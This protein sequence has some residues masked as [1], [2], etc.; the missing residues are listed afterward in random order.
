LSDEIGLRHYSPKT[1]RTY[2][3]YVLKFQIFTKSIDP[4]SLN[5]EHVKEFLD[6]LAAIKKVSATTQNLAFNS[7][8]F[9]F[10]HVLGKEFG[11]VEGVLRAKR[12]PS[13]PVIL[14]RTEIDSVLQHI[15]PAFALIVKM[16]Y[17]CGLRLFECIGLR[18]QCVNFDAGLLTIYDGKGL[19]DRTVPLPQAIIPE[20][21]AHV[22]KLKDLHRLDLSNEYAGVFLDNSWEKKKKNTAREFTWQWLFPAMQLTREEGTGDMRRYHLHETHVQKA[23][24]RAVQASGIGKRATAHTFRHSYASHLLQNNFDI[25]AIQELLGHGDVRTTM[26]YTRTVKSRS[27]KEACSPLDF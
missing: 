15:E 27:I 14:S 19:R 3:N 5:A 25:R 6:E 2:Q 24:K 13:V 4:Q 26:I 8:L 11:K 10:R 20:L 22:T 7:L 12:R 21:R 9:F 17:G 23:I 16:L 1:M 18:V